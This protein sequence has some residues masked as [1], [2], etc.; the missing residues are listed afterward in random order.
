MKLLA[1]DVGNSEVKHAV[2]ENGVI[3]QVRRSP[4]QNV[5]DIAHEIAVQNLPV[6]LCSVRSHASDAIRSALR[7][8]KLELLIEIGSDIS[9]P[10]SGFYSGMGADRIADV[11]AAWEDFKGERAVAVIGLGTASTITAASRA[12][13]FKGGFITLGL[14]AVCATLTNALPELPAVD[15]RQAKSLEPGFDVYPSICR[16]TVA[17][18]VG[19]IEQWISIF[20]REIDPD[21]AVVATG[22]WSELLAPL[23]PS[24]NKVDPLLTLRGVWTILQL[25]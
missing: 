21:L 9:E 23:C 1:V 15:P 7:T 6:A 19:I 18:H 20:K 25:N 12:G 11:C 4:T 2:I 16:G 24:I 8:Q 10:V 13:I 5:S 17:A 14:G 22:G 3:G